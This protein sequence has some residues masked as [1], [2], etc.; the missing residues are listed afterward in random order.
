V[1]RLIGTYVPEGDSFAVDMTLE[2]PQMPVPELEGMLPALGIVLPRGSSLKGGAAS[3]KA[4]I[5]GPIDRLV[6]IGSLNMSNTQ[7]AGFNLSSKLTGIEKLAG[8]KAG[9]DTEI[10]QLSGDVKVTPE[11][12]A[13]SNLKIVV[14][15]IGDVAGGGTVGPDSALSFKMQAAVHTGGLAAAL[16]NEPVPFTV[17]GTCADPLFHADISAVVKDEV[18][19]LGKAAG[20]LVKGLLGGK[21]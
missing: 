7:L 20:G 13:V 2:G 9:A 15:A 4:T 19:G 8:I 1:T 5:Q 6:I 17:D 11:G 16:N 18:K 10:Q 12:I 21:K 14:P 3:V